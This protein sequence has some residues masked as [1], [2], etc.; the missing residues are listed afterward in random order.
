MKIPFVIRSWPNRP[1]TFSLVFRG[2]HLFTLSVLK[3]PDM[4]LL[5][6]MHQVLGENTHGGCQSGFLPSQP[7]CVSNQGAVWTVWTVWG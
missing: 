7:S 2:P 1:N 6:Y 5:D 4:L 3:V